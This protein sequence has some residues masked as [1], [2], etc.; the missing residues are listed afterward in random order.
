LADFANEAMKTSKIIVNE[1]SLPEEKKT[2]K[3]VAV[4]GIAGGEKFIKA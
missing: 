2:L 3:S 4:G 1:I